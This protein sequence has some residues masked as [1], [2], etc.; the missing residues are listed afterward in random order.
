MGKFWAEGGLYNNIY[1]WDV[2]CRY[3]NGPEVH[4][5]SEDIALSAILDYREKKETNGTTFFGTKGWI[6]LSRSSVQSNIP[7][8]DQK[9]NNFP[10]NNDGWINS[11][12]NMMGKRFISV[13]RGEESELCPLDE[14]II[15]DTISHMGDIAIRTGRK[16]T[17]DPVKG[18][19]IGDPEGNKLYIREMRSPYMV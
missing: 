3:Q 12:N 19:V 7:E 17:W 16:V 15:S 14:A 1:S 10:K 4:F 6:S 8:I 11:E 13:I 5:V 9:L 2:T 18:E